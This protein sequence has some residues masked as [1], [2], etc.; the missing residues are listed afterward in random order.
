MDLYTQTMK[1]MY[2][3]VLLLSSSNNEGSTLLKIQISLIQFNV[4]FFYFI[5]NQNQT[6][7]RCPGIR[8]KHICSCCIALTVNKCDQILICNIVSNTF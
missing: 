3:S 8:K 4:D 6:Y 1:Q 5:V 2:F 7:L